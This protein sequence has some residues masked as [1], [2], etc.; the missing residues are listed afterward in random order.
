MQAEL[1]AFIEDAVLNS[2]ALASSKADSKG[3]MKDTY[4]HVR[5]EIE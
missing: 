1:N 3:N 4:H 5:K 2:K